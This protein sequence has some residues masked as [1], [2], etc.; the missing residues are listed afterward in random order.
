MVMEE[1]KSVLKRDLKVAVLMGGTSNE[2]QISLQ[3]G[4]MIASAIKEAGLNVVAVDIRP[5]DLSILDDSTV[6]VFFPAL[7]GKFGEDGQL[8]QIFEDKNLVFAGSGP[9]ASKIAFDKIAAKNVVSKNGVPVV[10][11]VAVTANDTAGSLAEKISSLGNPLVVKPIAEG[12]SFGVQIIS[13]VEVAARAGME[14][15][16]RFGGCMIEKFIDGREITV[17]ILNGKA[18]PI[19]EIK[20]KTKF[21]DYDAKYVD[22]ATDYLFDTIKDKQLIKKICEMAVVCFES[23]GCRHWGR[24]DMIIAGDSTPYFLEINTLPG[25]TAHSLVP[26]AANKAGMSNSQLC[27]KII[28]A[29]LETFER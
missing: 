15:L 17:G 3:S 16:E 18:L 6:D 28:E 26:M 21:Y 1:S 29:A 9:K 11:H 20:S 22:D 19:I 2:R 4:E 14:T 10:E 25:F 5:D 13:G 8:Q 23:I 24:V 7:H 27:V 12:S